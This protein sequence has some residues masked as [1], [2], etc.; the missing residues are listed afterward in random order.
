[1]TAPAISEEVAPEPALT[2]AFDDAYARFRAAYG[3]TR[4]IQ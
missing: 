4:E 2:A 1:M 3:P